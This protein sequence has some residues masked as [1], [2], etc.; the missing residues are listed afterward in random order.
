M[1]Q[2]KHERMRRQLKDIDPKLRAVLSDTAFYMYHHF[3]VN[4]IITSMIRTVAENTAVGGNKKSAHLDGRAVDIRSHTMTKDQITQLK[5]YMIGVW[6]G[7]VHFL[8]HDSGAGEHIHI[9]INW[10]HATPRDVFQP[11]T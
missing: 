6:D 4:L 10:H 11:F 2:F 9:N 8:H 5:T 3:G 7:M 1:I